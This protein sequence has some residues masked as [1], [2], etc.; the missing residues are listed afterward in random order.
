ML[1]PQT[2]RLQSES[3]GRRLARVVAGWP[4]RGHVR[5]GHRPVHPCPG[6]AASRRPGRRTHQQAVDIRALPRLPDR[7]SP[8]SIEAPRESC[9]LDLPCSRPLLD[10]LRPGRSVQRL[11]A[12]DVRQGPFLGKARRATPGDLYTTRGI[13]RDLHDPTFPGRKASIEEMTPV[14]PFL[15]GSDGT[16]SRRLYPRSGALED[17]PGVRNPFGL[18]RYP[19]LQVAAVFVVLLLPLCIL[20]SAASLVLCYR[21]SGGEVRE[22]IKWLAFAASFVGAVYFGGLITQLLFA[23]EVRLSDTLKAFSAKLRDETDLD[24]LNAKLIRVARETMQ[25]KHASLWLPPN[26]ASQGHDGPTPNRPR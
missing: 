19:W 17:H 22:Q 2:A 5:R 1:N 20:T 12:C 18:E 16:Y 4:L 24:S 6:C 15:S 11:R 9:R 25:L 13:A 23:P 3:P 26:T 7:R 8:G 10:V 21:R 14:C